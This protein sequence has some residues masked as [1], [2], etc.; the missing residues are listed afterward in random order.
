MEEGRKKMMDRL[1]SLTMEFIYLIT[2]EEYTMVKKTS[3]DHVTL[4]SQCCMSEDWNWR[5]IIEPPPNDKKI[6]EVINKITELLTEEVPIR[7]QDVAIYFSME[8]W[9]YMERSKDTI[10]ENKLPLTSPD[11]QHNNNN[12]MKIPTAFPDIE[13]NNV[14]SDS[15]G[16][17]SISSNLHLDLHCEDLSSPPSTYERFHLDVHPTPDPAPC[18][19][20]EMLPRSEYSERLTEGAES[21]SSQESKMGENLYSCP[22]CGKCFPYKSHL[23]RHEIAHTGKRPYSCWECGKSF[24]Y[25]SAL[26]VHEM[27]HTGEKPHSCSQCGKCFNRKSA[28]SRHQTIHTGEKSYSC[29]IC[30]KCFSQKLHLLKHDRVHTGEKPYSCTECGRRFSQQWDLNR[31]ERLHTGEKPYSCSQC[32]RCFSRKSYL[33]THERVHTG[34]KPY[35]CSQCGKCFSRKL[36]RLKH[37][38]CHQGGQ[39]NGCV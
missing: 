35:P 19:G 31:H 16:K 1:L 23:L 18:T 26:L 34:V 27:I 37:E 4:G 22:E 3:D 8:E 20:G 21:V 2:G 17:Q 9:E 13:D 32:G 25:K 10:M 24:L 28:L 38:K 36:Y 12:T 11:G 30:G 29:S 15:S 14:T 5:T 6:L 7:C 33:I 39:P